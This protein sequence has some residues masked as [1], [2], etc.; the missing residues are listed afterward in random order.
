MSTPSAQEVASWVATRGGHIGQ[1]TTIFKELKSME[2]EPMTTAWKAKLNEL[3]TDSETHYM[4]IEFY[5]KQLAQDQALSDPKAADKE[6]ISVAE[7][8]A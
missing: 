6:R 2:S 3:M 4:K 7:A 5:T 8:D 1:L